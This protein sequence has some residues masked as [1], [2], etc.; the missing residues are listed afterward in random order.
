M[1]SCRT[2]R[3]SGPLPRILDSSPSADSAP[4]A[5]GS[6]STTI[7]LSPDLF[8][9]HS[10]L[11]TRVQRRSRT[12]ASTDSEGLPLAFSAGKSRSDLPPPSARRFY[13]DDGTT[14]VRLTR[15][16]RR[17]L[18]W[19]R[20][21]QDHHR[22]KDRKT[23][24]WPECAASPMRSPA[25]RLRD[26]RGPGRARSGRSGGPGLQYTLLRVSGCG[27]SYRGMMPA[28]GCRRPVTLDV[29]DFRSTGASPA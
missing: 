3:P 10:P 14:G 8:P 13:L 16:A 7:S 28:L 17:D 12:D 26:D 21:E 19:K 24:R 22:L 23:R 4:G 11:S 2:P 15:S 1:R 25:P 29:G 5:S 18:G 20:W 6:A 9:G 27:R